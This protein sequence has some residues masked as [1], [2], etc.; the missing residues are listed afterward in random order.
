MLIK[1]RP[2]QIASRPGHKEGAPL[3]T[4]PIDVPE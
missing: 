1:K 4:P 3:K 2:G